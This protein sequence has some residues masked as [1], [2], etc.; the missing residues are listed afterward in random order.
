MSDSEKILIKSGRDNLAL[1][2]FVPWDCNK[3]CPFCTTKKE[4][5]KKLASVDDIARLANDVVEHIP[6]IEDIVISGGEP[7]DDLDSLLILL[8]Q[9]P[10]HI[11]VSNRVFINTSFPRIKDEDR[12]TFIRVLAEI[13]GFNVSRHVGHDYSEFASLEEIKTLVGDSCPVRINVLLNEQVNL[14]DRSK[15]ADVIE[16]IE[17]LMSY[18]YF[19]IQLRANYLKTNQTKTSGDIHGFVLKKDDDMTSLYL[20]SFGKLRQSGCAVC[21]TI[22]TTYNNS[23][24][25]I[26]FHKGLKST[27]RYFDGYYE[28]NDVI[29]TPSGKIKLDWEDASVKLSQIELYS[30]YKSKR[31]REELERRWCRPWAYSRQC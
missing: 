17:S 26:S 16:H 7:L 1:T 3:N 23:D 24:K 22:A 27:K 25:V 6:D 11:R 18:G 31:E 21:F 4:Y 13:G 14:I 30:D 10:Y 28:V 8:H 15:S 12:N 20:S 29:I 9:L 2:I 5:A 19:D